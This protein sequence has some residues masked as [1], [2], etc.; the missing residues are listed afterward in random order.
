MLKKPI[1]LAFVSLFIFSASQAQNIQKST[2]KIKGD[3]A[4]GYRITLPYSDSQVKNSVNTYVKTQGKSTNLLVSW[5]VKNVQGLSANDVIHVN[6]SGGDGQS[7]VWFG[8]PSAATDDK[9]L[10]KCKSMAEGLHKQALKDEADRKIV[11]AQKA[12][13]FTVENVNSITDKSAELKTQI[14]ENRVRNGELKTELELN[15]QKYQELQ[16]LLETTNRDL[17]AEKENL[18]KVEK[19]LEQRKAEKRAI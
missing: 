17:E 4:E 16:Q 11:E 12:V 10:K 5:T 7:Q 18:Q 14:E 15:E 1:L 8:S 3:L 6:I 19:M 13:D 9:V 2:E